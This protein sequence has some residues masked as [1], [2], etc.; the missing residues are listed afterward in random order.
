MPLI[1]MELI[2]MELT[3]MHADGCPLHLAD[4][5]K[6]LASPTTFTASCAISTAPCLSRHRPNLA[7]ELRLLINERGDRRRDGLGF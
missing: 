5:L 7:D 4:V 1:I 6:I 2:I 3:S